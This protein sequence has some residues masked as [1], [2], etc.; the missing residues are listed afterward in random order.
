M[1]PGPVIAAACLAVLSCLRFVE[2]AYALAA[3]FAVLAMAAL[4]LG[5]RPHAASRAVPS[6][7]PPA[8]DVKAAM[9][10][11]ERH[12]RSWRSIALFGFAVSVAGV[13]VFPPMA[14]VVAGLSLYSVHRMRQSGRS[15]ELLGRAV[16]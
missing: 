14:L 3:L 16:G 2:Q 15:S 5:L 12:R 8:G 1:R 13:F 6:A 4:A 11:H 9:D 10:A 7:P